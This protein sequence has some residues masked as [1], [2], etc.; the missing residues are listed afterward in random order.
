MNLLNSFGISH[1]CLWDVWDFIYKYICTYKHTY[2]FIFIIISLESRENLILSFIINNYNVFYWSI[3]NF[4][5]YS[6]CV[7]RYMYVHNLT[8]AHVWRSEDKLKSLYSPSTLWVPG[9]NSVCQAWCL[10]FYTLSHLPSPSRYVSG[11]IAHLCSFESWK[12]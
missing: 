12:M 6:V 2:K 7:H 4:Y 5:A 3:S 1:N 9:S 8:M 11:S 10:H